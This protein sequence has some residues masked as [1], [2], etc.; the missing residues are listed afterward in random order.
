MTLLHLRRKKR[1]STYVLWIVNTKSKKSGIHG[2][3]SSFFSTS[4]RC[5]SWECSDD[6]WRQYIF[7]SQNK[8]RLIPN[9]QHNTDL[10]YVQ[11]GR[12]QWYR[13]WSWSWTTIATSRPT[14]VI[15][16]YTYKNS[17]TYK[18]KITAN[19]RFKMALRPPKSAAPIR[20]H[21]D[22]TPIEAD[23]A[24]QNHGTQSPERLTC[25]EKLSKFI[26]AKNLDKFEKLQRTITP[27]LHITIEKDYIYYVNNN[28]IM[29]KTTYI[30]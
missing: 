19:G 30:M 4:V 21:E 14:Y 13:G 8:W 29:A 6:D 12:T 9:C 27:I 7:N 22:S 17:K 25:A 2:T 3:G 5:W 23:H 20:T 18:L 1:Q 26:S 28:A 10:S 16:Y 24:T 11:M 15:V